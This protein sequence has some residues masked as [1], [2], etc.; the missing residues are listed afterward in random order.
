ML[1]EQCFLDGFS[2]PETIALFFVAFAL[3]KHNEMR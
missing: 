3:I 1:Y 2:P